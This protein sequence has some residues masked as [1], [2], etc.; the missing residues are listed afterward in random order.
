[1]E[2]MT[3]N[4]IMEMH[5]LLGSLGINVDENLDSA[6]VYTELIR[7]AEEGDR[8]ALYKLHNLARHYKGANEDVVKSMSVNAVNRLEGF[9]FKDEV[10]IDWDDESNILVDIGVAN[11]LNT[12]LAKA[13]EGDKVYLPKGEYTEPVT[14]DKAVTI[15]ALPNKDGSYPEVVLTQSVNVNAQTGTVDIENIT[16]RC[17]TSPDGTGGTKTTAKGYGV[18]IKGACDCVMKNVVF[19]ETKNYYNALFITTT[20]KVDLDGLVFDK[21]TYYH[22]IEIGT[23]TRVKDGLSIKNCVFKEGY[24]HNAISMYQYEDNANITI[25][26][27]EFYYSGNALRFSNVNNAH[28]NINIKDNVYRSTD[29]TPV[30]SL[31]NAAC[32][33]GNEQTPVTTYAGLSIFQNYT[34][35]QD[36][37][38]MNVTMDNNYYAPFE[39]DAIKVS[40]E[41][42]NTLAQPYYVWVDNKTVAGAVLKAPTVTFK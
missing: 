24:T 37:S 9:E 11:P 40:A 17:L 23:E 34:G 27:N 2:P 38:L 30:G 3:K 21:G 13:K 12:A 15:S 7:H 19:D 22:P 31:G 32:Y 16:F 29:P 35:T 6:Y 42:F 33:Y 14:L 36:F 25:E 18:E 41:S 39:G 10:I 4:E 8:T 20:G 1:M 5:Q 26:N 28:A